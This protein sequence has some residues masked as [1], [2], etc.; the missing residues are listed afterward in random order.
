MMER[1]R[2]AAALKCFH[3]RLLNALADY[4]F[5]RQIV[6]VV[7]YIHEPCTQKTMLVQE[8]LSHLIVTF[9]SLLN[10]L[11]HFSCVC[12]LCRSTARSSQVS[13]VVVRPSTIDIGNSLMIARGSLWAAEEWRKQNKKLENEQQI[14]VIM[15][16]V[17]RIG[18]EMMLMFSIGFHFSAST[19]QLTH[20]PWPRRTQSFFYWTL[21]FSSIFRNWCCCWWFVCSFSTSSSTPLTRSPAHSF[22]FSRPKP[23]RIF[24]SR[25]SF[26]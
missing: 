16:D 15:I 3:A 14:I 21:L 9:G 26:V 23:S 18:W 11:I 5:H 19:D 2:I 8:I 4:T 10:L 24:E 20:E 7:S 22:S 12:S 17:C 6:V 1:E 13:L 25:S